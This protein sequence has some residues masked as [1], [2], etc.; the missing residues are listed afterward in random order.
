MKL[1]YLK[2]AVVPQA[3]II[4]YLL[5]LSH[6]GGGK[7]KAVFF[8]RFGFTIEQWEVLADA[9]L[10]HAAQ[11]DVANVMELPD[12]SHYVIDG[13]LEA[14]DGRRPRLRVVWVIETGSTKPR[15]VSAYPLP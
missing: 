11:H 10:A 13:E 12:R 6:T 2:D 9:L 1:P 7:D 3:K 14:P 4:S 5:N 15:L 8:Y